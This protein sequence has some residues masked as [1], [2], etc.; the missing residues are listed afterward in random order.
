MSNGNSRLIIRPQKEMLT[1]ASRNLP[2]FC[3]EAFHKCRSRIRVS[4]HGAATQDCGEEGGSLQILLPQVPLCT[5]ERTCRSCFRHQAPRKF[6]YIVVARAF[7]S[8]THMRSL[9]RGA[10]SCKPTQTKW[11]MISTSAYK[12]Q[13]ASPGKRVLPGVSK[14]KQTGRLLAYEVLIDV[15]SILLRKTDNLS[16]A[17]HN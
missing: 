3:C 14:K 10:W 4:R 13:T 2:L 5:D 11:K 1:N 9:T 15:V 6:A 8:I 12:H 16:N 17:T 7:F